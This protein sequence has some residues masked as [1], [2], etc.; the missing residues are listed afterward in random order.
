MYSKT[1]MF[2]GIYFFKFGFSKTKNILANVK[3]QCAYFFS[4]RT[5]SYIWLNLRRSRHFDVFSC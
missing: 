2:R 3:S 5:F 1:Y 4:G